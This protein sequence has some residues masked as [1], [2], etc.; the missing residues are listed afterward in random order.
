MGAVP[1]SSRGD[2]LSRRTRLRSGET[3]YS[4]RRERSQ[5]EEVE[6]SERGGKE[7]RW[8]QKECEGE[9]EGKGGEGR[10][11]GGKVPE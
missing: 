6:G 1:C 2:A 3:D 10:V 7:L 9:G 4:E 11:W 5:R 8:K